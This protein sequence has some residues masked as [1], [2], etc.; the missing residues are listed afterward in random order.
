MSQP[1]FQR[2]NILR[3]LLV[4]PTAFLMHICPAEE[5]P[6]QQLASRYCIDCHNQDA[7]KGGLDLESIIEQPITQNSDVWEQVVRKLNTNQMPPQAAE[8]PNETEHATAIAHL[9]NV[10]DTAA[11]RSP[12]PGFTPALKRLNRTEYQNSIRDLLGLQIDATELLP[13]DESSNGFDNTLMRGL[14]PTLVSRYLNAASTI[15]QV[16]VGSPVESPAGKTYRIKPDVTQERH[17]LGLPLGTRGGGRFLHHFQQGGDYEV[18]V[19]LTRD[20][21]D[22]V[23]G[24]QG[25]HELLVLI[26][27]AQAATFQVERPSSGTLADFDDG[28]LRARFHVAAGPRHLGVTFRRKSGSLQESIRQ[29]LNVHY[30]LHRHPRLNPAIYEVSITGPYS[31]TNTPVLPPLAKPTPSQRHIFIARPNAQLSPVAAA[32]RVI[33]S[34]ARRAYRRPL[35]SE[36]KTRLLAFFRETNDE[37]GF[38]AGIESVVAAILTSPHFLLRLE[39]AGTQ[40]PKGSSYRISD[41]ELASRLSFF[42]W[43]SLPDG[44]LLELAERDQ[45]HQPEILSS[46]VQR[47]LADRK[48]QNLSTNFASQWLQLRN[49]E[50]ITP[51]AR[52]FPDFDENLRRAM[53]RETE[54]HVESMI[55]GNASVLDLLR[56]DHTFLNER[57]AKHYEIKGVHGSR[58]RRVG[59]TSQDRRGGLLRHASILTITSYATRT[60]PVVRGNWILENIIGSPAPPPPNDV[61]ALEERVSI[62]DS[63]TLRQRLLRHRQDTSCARCHDLM[64]PIGFAL[65]NYDAVGRWREHDNHTPILTH[66][67]FPNGENFAGIDDL[68][69][70]LLSEPELFA[71]TFTEKLLTF[72]LGRGIELHDGPA[73]RKIVRDAKGDHYRVSDI[74]LGIVRSVPFQMRTAQ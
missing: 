29:P 37:R 12:N 25:K 71:T 27:G 5:S 67:Q 45:L 38:D 50:S 63:S 8:K 57:L 26:D 73:I 41:V 74:V 47:M 34:L 22:D 23:E 51:D 24:L 33:Q 15:A 55:T 54:L 4:L 64:D 21:N 10:L 52:M 61:P 58:Y 20:R 14:S 56:A 28:L 72:A 62:D 43:S 1:S 65:E 53:R 60:S 49:L 42:L 18:Q 70:A 59:L 39:S 9:T 19:R 35:T 31:D 16:A 40:K 3:H 69:H 2:L 30:N 6:H 17:V 13:A 66:G 36:D 11:S 46:Q 7:A 44:E 32:T 48:C 68:E